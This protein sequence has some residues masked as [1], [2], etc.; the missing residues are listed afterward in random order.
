MA[1]EKFKRMSSN[2]LS[3]DLSSKLVESIFELERI[4]NISVLTS[5]I[6]IFSS[7]SG[8]ILADDVTSKS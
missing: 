4:S 5:S 3:E 1:L 8:F 2:V 7:D 6:P